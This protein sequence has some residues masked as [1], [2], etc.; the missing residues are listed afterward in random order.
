MKWMLLGLSNSYKLLYQK[1]ILIILN[2]LNEIFL[3]REMNNFYYNFLFVW[4]RNDK[5]I[6]AIY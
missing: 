6:T 2:V 1:F 3:S 5:K 4:I